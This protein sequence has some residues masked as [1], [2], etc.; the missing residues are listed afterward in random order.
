MS[1]FWIE[2]ILHGL[3]CGIIC[4]VFHEII[5]LTK[6]R[7]KLWQKSKKTKGSKKKAKKSKR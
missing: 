1:E 7:Y 2:T 4:A 5:D 6:R 3:L